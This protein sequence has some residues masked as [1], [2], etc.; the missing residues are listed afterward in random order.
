MIHRKK[1]SAFQFTLETLLSMYLISGIL[2]AL[3]SKELNDTNFSNIV[4]IAIQIFC[5]FLAEPIY[6]HS[7][8]ENNHNVEKYCSRKIKKYLYISEEKSDFELN[9]L[10][11]LSGGVAI[12]LTLIYFISVISK[13]TKKQS[14][15]IP[16]FKNELYI[17][18]TFT[19]IFILI[20][21][22]IINFS[23]LKNYLQKYI[24]RSI[25]KSILI[26]KK[27]K[28]VDKLKSID[29]K[30]EN[31]GINSKEI[32]LLTKNYQ[33]D[34]KSLSKEKREKIEIY[35]NLNDKKRKKEKEITNQLKKIKKYDTKL[36][37]LHTKIKN[38]YSF[39]NF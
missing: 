6:L 38:K 30:I 20:A 15:S 7:K 37:K 13:D 18:L 34:Y 21:L 22:L 5:T 8:I 3:T 2:I 32:E 26:E 27:R 31:L 10:K 25:K 16:A 17:N 36:Q 28:K 1:S 24:N 11:L 9:L 39:Y 33:Y 19:L 29:K 12:A 35:F 4:M 23:Q 14:L